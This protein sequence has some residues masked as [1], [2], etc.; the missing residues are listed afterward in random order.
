MIF[1]GNFLIEKG[2]LNFLQL[3][4]AGKFDGFCVLRVLRGEN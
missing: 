1:I 2:E 3:I 4:F